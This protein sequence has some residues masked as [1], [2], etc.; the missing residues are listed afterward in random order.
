MSDLITTELPLTDDERQILKLI[1][2]D[3]IPGSEEFNLPGADDPK[4][5]ARILDKGRKHEDLLRQ[6]INLIDQQSKDRFDTSFVEA[7]NTDRSTLIEALKTSN[8]MFVPVLVSITLQ[9]Y[10]QDPRVLESVDLEGRP[11]F[12]DGY[13]VEQGDWS[14]LDPVRNREKFYRKV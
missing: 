3:I 4:I 14:L 8:G 12:P 13:E 9:A 6:G 11:P 2:S 1:D 5:F 7:S 10:Y